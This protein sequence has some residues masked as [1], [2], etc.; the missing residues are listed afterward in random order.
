MKTPD[1][2]L[3]QV[4]NEIEAWRQKHLASK[5]VKPL[6]AFR[7]GKPCCEHLALIIMFTNMG[8]PVDKDEA[9]KWIQDTAA[10]HSVACKLDVQSIRKW[11]RD[12]GWPIYS[13][14]KNGVDPFGKPLRRSEY[15]MYGSNPPK[16]WTLRQTRA[17]ARIACG[18]FEEICAWHN[19]TC[20]MCKRGGLDKS[21]TPRIALQ[22]GH[23]DP[24][25]PPSLSNT[26]PLCEECNKFQLDSFAI[27]EEG[28]L[29]TILPSQSSMRFFRNLK[30]AERQQL[31]EMLRV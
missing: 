26:V 24:R 29:A 16:E 7:H 31:S 3:D 30:P 8:H 11:P 4:W 5:G 9:A 15:C 12:H 6:P 10:C 17:G 13:G 28:R 23:M 20:V 22:Q 21:G 25:H 1:K 18:T 14:D 19:F 2:P 27:D